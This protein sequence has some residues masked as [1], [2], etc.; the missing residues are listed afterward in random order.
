MISLCGTKLVFS[1]GTAVVHLAELGKPIGKPFSFWD[2]DYRGAQAGPRGKAWKKDKY[3]ETWTLAR[4]L[5]AAAAQF[6]ETNSLCGMWKGCLHFSSNYNM[7]TTQTQ[8]N[9]LNFNLK[10]LGVLTI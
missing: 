5:A 1:V 6:R 3:T 8:R 10:T 2:E 4:Q 7:Q 9:T